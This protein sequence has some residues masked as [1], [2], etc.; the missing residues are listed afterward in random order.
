MKEEKVGLYIEN[1]ESPRKSTFKKR[2]Q[3][4]NID[5]SIPL[6]LNILKKESSSNSSPNSSPSSKNT[7]SSKLDSKGSYSRIK[8]PLLKKKG[9]I[10][11]M[12]TMTPVARSSNFRITASQSS[13][14]RTMETLRTLEENKLD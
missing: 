5:S 4:T 14:K 7:K 10:L 1:Q 2:R 9:S 13:F 3:G 6:K 11:Q 12:G 8:G